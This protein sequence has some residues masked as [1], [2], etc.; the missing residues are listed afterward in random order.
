MRKIPFWG[1]MVLLAIVAFVLILAIPTEDKDQ[2]KVEG[3]VVYS[4]VDVQERDDKLPVVKGTSILGD[5]ISIGD[6]GNPTLVFVVAHWCPHCQREVPRI[7]KALADRPMEGVDLRAVST[8]QSES[9]GNWSPAQWLQGEDWNI[10]TLAD[11]EASTAGE[12]LGADSFPKFI[13]AD[14]DGEI[15]DE[16]SGELSE[17]ELDKLFTK[18][19]ELTQ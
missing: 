1:W 15:V 8:A 16:Q 7:V 10:P 3:E 4:E 2:P 11:D 13:L 5:Q 18:A 9:R 19:E 12:A 14:G 17:A 6:S